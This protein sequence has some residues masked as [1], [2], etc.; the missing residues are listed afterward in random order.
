MKSRQKIIN[1]IAVIFS[2]IFL[3]ASA[4]FS[5]ESEGEGPLKVGGQIQIQ[6]SRLR[7]ANHSDGLAFRRLRPFIEKTVYENWKGRIQWDFAKSKVVIKDAYIQNDGFL[8]TTL[9]LGN[10]KTT[11]SRAFLTS[12][13]KHQLV[14]ISFVGDTKYGTPDRALGLKIEGHNESK[15]V[16]YGLFAGTEKIVTNQDTLQFISP[17]ENKGISGVVGSDDGGWLATAR[18]DFH[19]L[20]P[21]A[22]SQGNLK[23]KTKGTLSVAAL[24]WNNI[25]HVHSTSS[26]SSVDEVTGL[27]GSIAARFSGMSVDVQ[28]NSFDIKTVNPAMTGGLYKAG[29]TTL[30]QLA[31]EAGYMIWPSRVELVGGYEIQDADNYAAKWD[32]KSAGLNVFLS[33]H[34]IKGQVTYRKS[35]N[36]KGVVDK[37]ENELFVQAQFLF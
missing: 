19:P 14:E 29:K 25:D 9:T 21:L 8:N 24:K 12:D 11:F 3:S 26:V 2:I 36:V 15:K 4:G 13:T 35:K 22:F 7:G 10:S 28:Y 31:V 6:A 37:N 27:E 1:G 34:E 20:G 30:T 17:E 18:L 5:A 23:K 33:G 32:R 16:A